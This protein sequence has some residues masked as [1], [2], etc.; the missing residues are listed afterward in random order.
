MATEKMRA[1]TIENSIP[2]RVDRVDR[3]ALAEIKA[4]TGIPVCK[5]IHIAVPLLRRKYRIKSEDKGE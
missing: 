3:D 4:Y 1:I 2:L 5:L